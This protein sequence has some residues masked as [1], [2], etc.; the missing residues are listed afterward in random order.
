MIGPRQC[1]YPGSD[2]ELFDAYRQAY[3]KLDDN[4]VDEKSPNGTYTLSTNV[5]PAKAVDF[6]EVWLKG[7][8]LM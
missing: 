4:K 6:V 2:K 8:G 5:I 7:Q 3:A 1:D